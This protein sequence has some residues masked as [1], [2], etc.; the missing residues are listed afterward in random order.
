MEHLTTA[1]ETL[2]PIERIINR[3]LQLL[4]AFVLA[5]A[6]FLLSKFY[7]T[8]IP[9][10][11]EFT[12]TFIDAIGV[13]FSIAPAGL[14]FMI[15]LTYAGATVDLAH[16]GALVQEARSVETLAQT[17]IVCFGKA[18]FLTSD[19]VKMTPVPAPK[20]AEKDNKPPSEDEIRKMLGT[21]ARSSSMRNRFIQTLKQAFEGEQ[22]PPT[23]EM[24][25]LGIYGWSGV[26]LD[27]EDVRGVFVLSAPDELQSHLAG[28]QKQDEEP[29]KGVLKHVKGV[30]GRLGKLFGR[31]GKT[32]AKPENAVV[33]AQASLPEISPEEN[34][35]TVEPAKAAETPPSGSIFKRWGKSITARIRRSDATQ[36]P[37]SAVQKKPEEGVT[38]MFAWRPDPAPLHDETGAPRLPDGLIPLCQLTYHERINPEAVQAL[39]EFYESGVQIAIFSSDP[40]EKT[41]EELH[42]AGISDETASRLA[43]I[44][45]DALA[46]MDEQTFAQAV[47]AHQIFGNITAVM[48]TRVVQALRETGHRVGVVGAGVDEIHAMLNA[49]ISLTTLTASSGALSIAD[50]ILLET[51]PTVTSRII[52]KGQRIVNGLLD[53]LKIYLTQALYLLLLVLALLFLLKSFPYKGAQ[54]GLIAVFA[55]SIPAV[56]ITLTAPAGRLNAHHLGR[57]LAAFVIPAGVSIAVAGYI[58]F[59]RFYHLY[60]VRAEAQIGLVH[61]LVLIGLLLAI[62]IR[63]PIFFTTNINT[64]ARNLLTTIV[65]IVSGAVFLLTT[66]IKLAQKFLH[67]TPLKSFDDYL[68]VANV[69][70]IW[71]GGFAV[72]LLLTFGVKQL[73]GT[74]QRGSSPQ[75]S[76]ASS[77]G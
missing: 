41:L 4:L 48:M 63:P 47:N 14:F 29:S 60:D 66:H 50:I 17:D 61:G 43:L 67:I 54:G 58:I 77:G 56:A 33:P 68:F 64:L 49:D 46:E 36:Q 42:S 24:P 44:S 9:F 75:E 32:E 8:A 1:P 23:D 15:V 3:T 55:I 25:F 51:S 69:S 34:P 31:K 12:D 22:L 7:L 74:I 40:A 13:I 35:A 57:Y 72:Y 62:L 18:G 38:L 19:W 45:G 11:P 39:G 37:E 26:S 65:A 27:V 52:D 21:F 59:A 73:V 5:I 10:P 20:T 70:L 76:S 28:E 30:G 2:T 6:A 16:R 53:V 71:A